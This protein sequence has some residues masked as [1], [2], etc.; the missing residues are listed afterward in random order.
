[1]NSA[2][3]VI[4]LTLF[5]HV[6]AALLAVRL[7]RLTRKYAAGAVILTARKFMR[8]AETISLLLMDVIMPKKNGKE[9]YEEIRKISPKIKAC[10]VSGYASDVIRSGISPDDEFEFIPKP[11]QPDE[12][13]KKIRGILDA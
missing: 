5:L 1:M 11:A 3:I 8:Q 7:M 4:C 2:V 6:Y 13:L 10:F 12:L 9:A